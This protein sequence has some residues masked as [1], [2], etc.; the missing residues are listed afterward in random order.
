MKPR[1]PPAPTRPSASLPEGKRVGPSVRC[2]GLRQGDVM[3]GMHQGQGCS[4]E[5]SSGCPGPRVTGSSCPWALIK[6][7]TA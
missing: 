5:L 2:A 3:G 4:R 6:V 7:G 1:S